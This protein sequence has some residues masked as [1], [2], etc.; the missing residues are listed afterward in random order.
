ML[1]LN[2]QGLLGA[3]YQY[4]NVEPKVRLHR[5]NTYFED[6]IQVSNTTVLRVGIVL[7]MIAMA[8]VGLWSL[9]GIL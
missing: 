3:L 5:R 9:G 2:N 1:Q 6:E 8:I 7:S 4:W